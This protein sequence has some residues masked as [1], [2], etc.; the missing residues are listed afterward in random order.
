LEQ[1]EQT[2]KR[3][4][5][6]VFTAAGTDNRTIWGSKMH[7]NDSQAVTYDTKKLTVQ[8]TA[9]KDFTLQTEGLFGSKISWTSDK[10]A[11]Q[12]KDGKAAVK[13]STK[14]VTV[15]LTATVTKG[16]AKQTKTFTVTVPKQVL[17]NYAEV[18]AKTMKMLQDFDSVLYEEDYSTMVNDTAIATR[19]TSV[20]K[21]NCL[22]VEADSTHDSFIKFAAGNT[23]TSQGAQTVFDIAGQINDRYA[24]TFD[25]ALEAG[26]SDTSEFAIMG[27]DVKFKN[28]DT[29]AGLE[30]GY[31]LKLQAKNST[32]WSINGS[33]ETFE[34]PI[35]WVTVTAVVDTASKTANVVIADDE[36]L[37]Y[38]GKV[39][40]NGTGKPKGLYL[41]WACKQSLVSVDN[42]KVSQ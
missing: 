1:Y 25:V 15:T 35:T 10:D 29:N 7:K 28:D 26:S 2:D 16:T 18:Q 33:E 32:K 5:V 4:K 42:V 20:N 9:A 17:T 21:Q 14:A 12:I 30:S 41:R 22:Y 39:G 6:M 36:N 38:A 37:Y 23:S 24:V 27:T 34:L 31:I 8:E 11:I 3:E 13:Q 19:W 40:I